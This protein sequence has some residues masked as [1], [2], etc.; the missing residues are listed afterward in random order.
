MRTKE[1]ILQGER[2]VYPKGVKTSSTIITRKRNL[3]ERERQMAII[4]ALLDI[5]DILA[6][7]FKEEIIVKEAEKFDDMGEFEEAVK[8]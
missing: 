4:E 5:R 1:E 3:D 8:T 6:E 7:A 2:Q